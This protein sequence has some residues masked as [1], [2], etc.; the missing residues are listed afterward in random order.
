[1]TAV[2][3]SWKTNYIK[4]RRNTNY[5]SIIYAVGRLV[6]CSKL[7]RRNILE[8]ATNPSYHGQKFHL[9]GLSGTLCVLFCIPS[10]ISTSHIRDETLSAL[11]HPN[12]GVFALIFFQ[13][14]HFAISSWVIH[15]FCIALF[16]FLTFL[17]HLY[18]V[19]FWPFR[20]FLSHT[21]SFSFVV[22]EHYSYNR[23][24]S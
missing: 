15:L 5:T 17:T 14:S 22:R 13:L 2:S 19:I 1:M 3:N 4:S 8:E 18:P 23:S 7:S 6:H 10:P 24:V 20:F 21:L 12:I 16:T 11:F 9:L